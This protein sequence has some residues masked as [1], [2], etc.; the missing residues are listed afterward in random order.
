M[1]LFLRGL[2]LRFI[3]HP[4]SACQADTES[5]APNDSRGRP[6]ALGVGDRAGQF[7]NAVEGTNAGS[8][9]GGAS[10]QPI[11]PHNSCGLR[12]LLIALGQHQVA[13]LV[14]EGMLQA[15]GRAQVDD[16][17]DCAYLDLPVAAQDDSVCNPLAQL[18]RLLRGDGS[19]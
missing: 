10:E 19:A 6:G 13:M 3:E 12:R 14:S 8:P 16:Q 4:L 5:L 15:A 9:H 17:F 7:K 1:T 18:F 11:S 2:F